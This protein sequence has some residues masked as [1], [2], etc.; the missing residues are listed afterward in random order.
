MIAWN[1][2]SSD[3]PESFIFGIV[4]LNVLNTNF[5]QDIEHMVMNYVDDTKLRQISN[6]KSGAELGSKGDRR[7]GQI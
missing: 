2:F 1:Q 3:V 7:V 5:I 4:P 6:A